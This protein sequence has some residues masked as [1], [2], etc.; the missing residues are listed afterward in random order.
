MNGPP[1]PIKPGDWANLLA[2]LTW[3]DPLGTGYG[4]FVHS[5]TGARY[6][7]AA[8]DSS[9]DTVWLV[10]TTAPSNGVMEALLTSTTAAALKNGTTNSDGSVAYGG[11]TYHIK[12]VGESGHVTC[13]AV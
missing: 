8:V 7:V 5:S 10:S 12:L 2:F 1:I 4:H 3:T 13:K 6:Y 9:G 11:T